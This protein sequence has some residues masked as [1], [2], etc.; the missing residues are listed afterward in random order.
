ML[1][2]S[3]P[4][5]GLSATV[6]TQ[7]QAEQTA[8]SA[9]VPKR[10]K[11]RWVPTAIT[12][13]AAVLAICVYTALP[14][15]HGGVDGVD[16]MLLDH[17]ATVETE[18]TEQ[19]F[20]ATPDSIVGV[21]GAQPMDEGQNEAKCVSPEVAKDAESVPEQ[22]TL[23]LNQNLLS[24]RER[25]LPLTIAEAEGLLM[26]HLNQEEVSFSEPLTYL[27]TADGHYQFHYTD[28]EGNPWYCWISIEDGSL[29]ILDE[30]G[31]PMSTTH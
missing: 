8:S 19:A 27:S 13:A 2:R 7:I 18:G 1:F 4:P 16:S 24:T 21:R 26:E 28:E 9:A 3:D 14:Y 11:P 23:S 12:A 30:M 22:A 15:L 10:K 6:M 17:A 31:L 25:D 29:F 5:K 20:S